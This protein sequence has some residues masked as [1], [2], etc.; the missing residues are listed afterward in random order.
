MLGFRR[1]PFQGWAA[2]AGS[3][4][5]AEQPRVR[6]WLPVKSGM[7]NFREVLRFQHSQPTRLAASGAL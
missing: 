3:R 2:P 7:V 4:G 5:G 6:A 1:G